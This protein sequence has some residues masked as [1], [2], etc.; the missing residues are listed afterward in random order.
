MVFKVATIF[1]KLIFYLELERKELVKKKE[2]LDH[3]SIMIDLKLCEREKMIKEISEMHSY[4][5]YLISFWQAEKN[6]HTVYY[7]NS[8]IK[9][10]H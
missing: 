1:I 7:F 3:T 10:N 6:T 5:S 2:M 4:L 9:Y 8:K